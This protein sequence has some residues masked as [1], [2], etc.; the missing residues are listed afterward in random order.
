MTKKMFKHMKTIGL[1]YF[2]FFLFDFTSPTFYDELWQVLKNV[3]LVCRPK[4][5]GHL[6]HPTVNGLSSSDPA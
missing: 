3:G 2:G 1:V 5:L 4:S 6:H